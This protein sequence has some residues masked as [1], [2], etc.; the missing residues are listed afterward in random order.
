MLRSEGVGLVREAVDRLIAA[1]EAGQSEQLRA[2]LS[3]MG[4]FRRYSLGNLLLI[5]LACPHASHVAGYRTWQ[6]LG[7][8]VRRGERGIRILA[9][10]VYHDGGD[11]G[12]TER[13]VAFNTAHVFDV[14][15]TDG[16]P[17]PEFAQVR[18]NPHVYLERLKA[19]IAA[20]G[21]DLVYGEPRAGVQGWSAG[22][23]IGVRK[24]LSPGE[25]FSVLVHEL[26]HQ[27]LHGEGSAEVSRR[28]RETEAEAVAFVVCEA[29]GL[30]T[31]GASSD[32]VSLYAGDRDT[33]LNSLGRIQ[34]TASAIIE[35]LTGENTR[36]TAWGEPLSIEL[37]RPA[38]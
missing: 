37:K 19:A 4:R 6:R 2:Y 17:L 16:A 13:V 11:T 26:T 38:A 25:E 28:V 8:H 35:D 23:R 24:G 32:Y 30:D 34:E 33:L 14:S 36:A 12:E 20:R 15:Q 31:N 18:G 3:A 27:A 22:R 9:P 21:I 10:I 5:C 7:R 29:I 1:L